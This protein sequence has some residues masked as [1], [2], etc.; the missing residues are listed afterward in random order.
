MYTYNSKS[1]DGQSLIHVINL[2]LGEDLIGAEIGVHT[3]LTSC[4]ILQ[5]CPNI[6][7]LYLVDKYKPYEDYICNNPELYLE[8]KPVLVREIKE[9]EYIKFTAHHNV[10][11]SGFE[12]KAIFIEEDS[13]VVSTH[14]EN[15]KL[16]F[17]FLDSFLTY[18]DTVDCLD[19]WY[20]KVRF[21]GLVSGHDWDSLQVQKAV[22][23]FREKNNITKPMSVFDNTWMWIK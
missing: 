18:Q 19:D 15:E 6:K 10:K 4:T 8:D 1:V 23:E 17:V 14:T 2:L 9:I 21:G 20:S 7:L 16:D 3:A 5:N 13:R 11:W 22:L 12:H